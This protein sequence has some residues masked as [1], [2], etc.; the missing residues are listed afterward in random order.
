MLTITPSVGYSNEVISVYRAQVTKL[1]REGEYDFGFYTKEDVKEL[2]R[3]G[4]IIDAQ[5]LGSLSVWLNVEII[6]ASV[7]SILFLC[8]GNYY[9]SRFCE[10]YLDHLLN[11]KITDS[12]GLMA[13]RKLNEGPISEHTIQYL[14]ELEVN[15]PIIRFPDQ[16]EERHFEQVNRVIALDKSEHYTM[17]QHYFPDWKDKIEYW[18]VHDIDKTDPEQALPTLKKKVEELADSLI[19]TET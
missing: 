19:G 7:P 6:Q 5:S 2:I 3:N 4:R 17:M 18:D 15:L 9:R 12:K 8:T 10:I 16:M 14:D 13:Y 1:I 11:E